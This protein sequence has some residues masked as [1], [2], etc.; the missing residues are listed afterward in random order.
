MKILFVSALLPYPLTSGGQVRMFNL[1]KH[2]AKEHDI[3][4]FSFI[5]NEQEKQYISKLSFLS[6]VE[7][8]MRGTAWQFQYFAKALFGS[9]PW[10]LTTYDN[11]I[12]RQRIIDELANHTYD[13]LHIEPFYVYPSIPR[14]AMPLVVAEHNVEY[15]VYESYA[16]NMHIPLLRS[17][18]FADVVKLKHWEIKT[19]KT[20]S[21]IICVSN[22]DNK[23]INELIHKNN[24]TTISNGVDTSWFSYSERK[25]HQLIKFIFIGNYAWLPNREALQQLLNKIWPVIRKKIPNSTLTI[26]GPN[27]S[28]SLV[29]FIK[30]AGAIY[31]GTVP[32]IRK[33]YQSSDILLAPMG[34]GGGTKFKLLEA[35]ASGLPIITT[36]EGAYGLPVTNKK[37]LIIAE[38]DNVFIDEIIR[39]HDRLDEINQMTKR[40]RI[41]V[42][43]NYDWKIIAGRLS[44][45]W[46]KAYENA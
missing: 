35:M 23:E 39:L 29:F 33:I 34:I 37:E 16:K 31:A 44:G 13:I 17:L 15:H 38:S 32:D 46:K 21:Q 24:V 28:S 43:Q 2:A 1:L 36:R 3:T 45:V 20:A 14:L 6:R 8:V 11:A 9:Y 12:M 42:E 26:V 27:M 5:R 30:R 4:L 19:L 41:F 22:T 7:T 25:N 18:C 10:L 40:A